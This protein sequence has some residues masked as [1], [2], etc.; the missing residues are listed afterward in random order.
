MHC[1]F[2]IYNFYRYGAA[3]NECFDL[4]LVLHHGAFDGSFS[5]R[6]LD[7]DTLSG[8]SYVVGVREYSRLGRSWSTSM[9]FLTYA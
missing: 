2:Q 4:F 5:R 6:A 8:T 1:L 3:I 9:V 7:Y